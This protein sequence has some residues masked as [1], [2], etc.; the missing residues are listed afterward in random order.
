MYL[1]KSP[2]ALAMVL[3]VAGCTSELESAAFSD[4]QPELQPETFFAGSTTST[5]VLE[6]KR[7]APIHRF[8]VRGIGMMLPDGDLRLDQVIDMEQ[9]PRETRTWILRKVDDHHFEGTL[10]DTSGQVKAEAYGNLIHIRYPMRSPPLGEME[11]WLYLQPDGRT[12]FNEAT[13]SLLGIVAAHLSE[14]ITHEPG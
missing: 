6:N 9:M 8:T 14:R 4:G 10:T 1:T 12:V 11:Q 3:I 5:G 7:G 2:L 13:I